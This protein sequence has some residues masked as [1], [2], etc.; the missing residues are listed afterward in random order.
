LTKYITEMVAGVSLAA[1][2]FGLVHQKICTEGGW[3]NW[4]QFIHH[5]NHETLILLC[6]VATIALLVGKYINPFISMLKSKRRG[7]CVLL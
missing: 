3:F 7:K 6:F 4:E 2:I 1:G 5:L